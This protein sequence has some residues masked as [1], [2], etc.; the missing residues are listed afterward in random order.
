VVIIVALE[1]V[2]MSVAEIII[3]TS[4]KNIDKKIKERTGEK[5]NDNN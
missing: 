3:E 1:V 4:D 5:S 2:A